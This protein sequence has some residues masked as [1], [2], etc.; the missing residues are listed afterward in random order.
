MGLVLRILAVV[1][2]VPWLAVSAAFA[3]EHVHE[4]DASGHASVVH[5]HFALHAHDAA[6]V[7]DAD[8]HGAEFS[9]ADEHVLWLD[10][11][12]VA[13]ASYAF[14]QFLVVHS[15]VVVIASQAVRNTVAA[16]DEATLPHGP[17]RASLSL[18][19]PPAVLL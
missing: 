5:A 4:S 18:R 10:Q 6:H 17:P 15:V 16:A 14:P 8:H 9:D 13:P 11:V 2:L 19:A 7:S 1:T 12:G 3:R